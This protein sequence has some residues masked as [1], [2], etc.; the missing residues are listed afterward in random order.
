MT[1]EEKSIFASVL[2]KFREQFP[3]KNINLV[4]EYGDE[5]VTIDGEVK[6]NTTGYN[7]LYNLYRLCEC[8]KNELI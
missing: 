3:D 5:L 7:L 8:L 1:N 4:G 2:A 6:F